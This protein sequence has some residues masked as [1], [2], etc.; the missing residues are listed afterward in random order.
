MG[1]SQG[2]AIPANS[3]P[4]QR[5]ADHLDINPPAQ[6]S[7]M[8]VSIFKKRSSPSDCKKGLLFLFI[9]FTPAQ[10]HMVPA[11]LWQGNVIVC[12]S[13]LMGTRFILLRLVSTYI[14]TFDVIVLCGIC[15]LNSKERLPYLTNVL[16]SSAPGD[17]CVFLYDRVVVQHW[18]VLRLEDRASFVDIGWSCIGLFS[19]LPSYEWHGLCCLT[20]GL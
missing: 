3:K 17:P 13:V 18:S 4:P 9:W 7:V 16:V 6:L 14:E 2:L 1:P 19:Q 8:Y 5:E 15:D 12:F 10:R 20:H 11:A